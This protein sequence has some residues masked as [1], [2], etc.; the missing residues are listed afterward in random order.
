MADLKLNFRSG[1]ERHTSF[2]TPPTPS[3]PTVPQQDATV[4]EF[5]S[6]QVSVGIHRPCAGI[7]AEFG[8]RS[9][10]ISSRGLTVN[11]LENL[12]EPT[13]VMNLKHSQ[14]HGTSIYFENATSFLQHRRVGL[15][16][17]I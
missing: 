10:I 9:S 6:A 14:L 7:R 2:K 5:A 1:I 8:T 15:R 3:L 16:T 11:R 12:S 13:K 17:E 4:P